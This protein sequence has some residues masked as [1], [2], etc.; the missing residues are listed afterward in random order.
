M[1]KHRKGPEGKRYC[2][3]YVTK[4]GDY[5]E[6]PSFDLFTVSKNFSKEYSDYTAWRH[7]RSVNKLKDPFPFKT[8]D[9]RIVSEPSAG[10]KL[11]CL[12]IIGPPSSGKTLWAN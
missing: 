3:D 8:P 7:Y 10:E 2:F 5:W 9:D 12:W 4:D 11:C 6:S 1:A